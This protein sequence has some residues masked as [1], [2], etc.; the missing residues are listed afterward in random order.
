M[1]ISEFQLRQMLDRLGMGKRPPESQSVDPV[2][3]GEELGLHAEIMKYCNA[4]W[5]PWV[6]IHTDPKRKSRATPGAPDFV[7]YSCYGILSVE[8]KDRTGKRSP[9]QTQFAYVASLSGH[10]IPIVR[11]MQD[12]LNVIEKAKTK[13]G[14][15]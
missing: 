10:E 13:K 7:I 14:P 5:P 4:Q 2:G 3:D 1:G 6:F 11:S 12:F 9:E 8:C 15:T